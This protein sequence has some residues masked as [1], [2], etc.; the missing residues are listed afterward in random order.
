MNYE[1]FYYFLIGGTIIGSSK[2]I[3]R[4]LSPGISAIVG[5]VPNAFITIFFLDTSYKMKFIDG[6]LVTSL[7]SWVAGIYIKLMAQHVGAKGEELNG[8]IISGIVMW[9]LLSYIVIKHFNIGK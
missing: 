1:Y 8:I 5:G 3:S 7:L 6:Y 9:A 4:V 2:A